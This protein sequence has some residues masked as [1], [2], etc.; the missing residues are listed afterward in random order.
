[1]DNL[2]DTSKI[3]KSYTALDLEACVKLSLLALAVD[4]R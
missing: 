1:M 4:A 3:R 2:S